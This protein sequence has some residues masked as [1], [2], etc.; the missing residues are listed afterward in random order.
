MVHEKPLQLE[1]YVN[2]FKNIF[3][4]CIEKGLPYPW[5]GNGEFYSKEEYQVKLNKKGNEVP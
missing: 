5:D 2:S 4:D 3:E 1:K